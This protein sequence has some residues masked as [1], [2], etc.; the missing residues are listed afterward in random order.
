MA[1]GRS[2]SSKCA[3]AKQIQVLLTRPKKKT[4]SAAA[5]ASACKIHFY[6]V[7]NPCTASDSAQALSGSLKGLAQ[8]QAGYDV[9]GL[10]SRQA[11]S[12]LVQYKMDGDLLEMSALRLVQYARDISGACQRCSNDKLQVEVDDMSEWNVRLAS[13]LLQKQQQPEAGSIVREPTEFAEC[14]HA[15]KHLRLSM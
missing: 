5:P 8:L 15:S 1:V 14:Q 7:W 11:S 9:D 4:I 3:K 10:A 2:I 12:F 13:G 6:I